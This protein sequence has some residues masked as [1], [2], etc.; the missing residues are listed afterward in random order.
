MTR[1]RLKNGFLTI[2]APAWRQ[3]SPRP[4]IY[5]PCP[6]ASLPLPTSSDYGLAVFPALSKLIGLRLSKWNTKI[7]TN[8]FSFQRPYC[9]HPTAYVNIEQVNRQNMCVTDRPTDLPNRGKHVEILRKLQTQNIKKGF[10]CLSARLSNLLSVRPSICPSI[11]SPVML[12]WC[13]L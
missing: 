10:V 3:Y 4:L 8:E 13:K 9:A 12:Q 1:N 7:V 6:L 2:T 11:H 5:C